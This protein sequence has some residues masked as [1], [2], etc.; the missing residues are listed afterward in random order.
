VSPALVTVTE[1]EHENWGPERW[2]PRPA[3]RHTELGA[4]LTAVE[5]HTGAN[6]SGERM[7]SS[8]PLGT[9]RLEGIL[10]GCIAAG[11]I[12]G[13]EPLAELGTRRATNC[14]NRINLNWLTW[15]FRVF[16]AAQRAQ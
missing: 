7:P 8:G 12:W 5:G 15:V 16:L 1:A 10:K 2:G 13:T 3:S 4:R 9:G 14:H 6:A 11:S